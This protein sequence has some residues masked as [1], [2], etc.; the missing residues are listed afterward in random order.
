MIDFKTAN[1]ERNDEWNKNYYIQTLAYALMYEEL[2]G[3]P[4]EQIVI[5]MAS[6]DGA[7]R[8][9]VKN[10]SITCDLEE[11]IKYFYKYYEEKTKAQSSHNG[12]LK[13]TTMLKYIIL[14]QFV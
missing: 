3:T 2:F 5:L 13:R 7:G 6:E 14:L 9:F 1:K 4:I 10:K 8:V 11:A 12:L